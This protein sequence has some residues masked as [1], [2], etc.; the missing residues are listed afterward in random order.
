M[1]TFKIEKA[2]ER[3]FY[4]GLR[5]YGSDL[6]GEL[7][8]EYGFSVEE[9][10][11][12]YS[13]TSA[14]VVTSRREKKEPRAKVLKPSMPM[15]WCGSAEMDGEMC[16]GLR[17]NHGLYTQCRNDHE[18]GEVLC[19]TCARS[20]HVAGRG[21]PAYGTIEDRLS[22]GVDFRDPSGKAPVPYGN[23]LKK[24]NISQECAAKEALK[25]GIT[26]SDADFVVT[27]GKRGRPKKTTVSDSDSESTGEKRARGR[28]KKE[29][30]VQSTGDNLIA[31]LAQSVQDAPNT[32]SSSN[33][34]ERS[35][36]QL[37]AFEAAKAK[38]A[39]NVASKN[40]KISVPDSSDD[41]AAPITGGIKG[42]SRFPG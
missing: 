14:L 18:G 42:A 25:F 22:N 28:P 29:R 11:E 32:A 26:L 13:S 21:G 12:K 16:H 35:S 19:K 31:A 23:V 20:A 8:R 30:P 40:D 24:L 3:A 9:A 27:E 15:P 1:T 2:M 39:A 7:A 41:D 17:L 10:H 4:A 34:K 37:V 5:S 6:I 36:A 38:R 33:T